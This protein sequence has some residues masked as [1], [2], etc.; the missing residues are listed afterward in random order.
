MCARCAL[1]RE[2]TQC[3]GST[4]QRGACDSRSVLSWC[5]HATRLSIVRPYDEAGREP[6]YVLGSAS[7]ERQ[8]AQRQHSAAHLLTHLTM[9]LDT[10][11]YVC[12]VLSRSRGN[13]TQRR[14][15]S[16]RSARYGNCTRE[17]RANHQARSTHLTVRRWSRACLEQCC[18]VQEE[19]Q[20]CAAQCSVVRQCEKRVCLLQARTVIR[21]AIDRHHG[22]AG[23][24][25]VCVL[26]A[27]SIKR[28]HSAAQCSVR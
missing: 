16:Q 2:A 20:H 26:D 22:E 3:S 9:R 13:T 7:I 28:Q 15:R 27:A 21:I 18:L 6:V 19:I 25:R 12:K 5:K 4:G 17:L 14:H 1:D 11:L 8:R 23:C 10:G 24:V